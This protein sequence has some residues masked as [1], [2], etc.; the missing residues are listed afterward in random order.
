MG[1]LF[2]H[3]VSRRCPK[4]SPHSLLQNLNTAN[5]NLT[6]L[7]LILLQ[8]EPELILPSGSRFEAP[9][10]D[11]GNE[12]YHDIEED[13]GDDQNG[14]GEE[15]IKYVDPSTLITLN[16]QTTTTLLPLSTYLRLSSLLSSLSTLLSRGHLQSSAPKINMSSDLTNS[17][18][19]R[20]YIKRREDV[21]IDMECII[22][23]S[24]T[25]E[26]ACQTCATGVCTSCQSTWNREIDGG[27]CVVCREKGEGW[28]ITEYG[29]A[30]MRE[31]VEEVVEE[32]RVIL[33]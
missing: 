29:E 12:E 31:G 23:L 11:S 28:N 9:T 18:R 30:E 4:L 6:Q 13:E 14:N 20:E 16:Q 17:E 3:L 26:I 32:I 10:F 1:N 22:C 2:T 27:G 8:Y 24:A 15:D 19:I 7:R 25:T 21:K 5:E 33:N